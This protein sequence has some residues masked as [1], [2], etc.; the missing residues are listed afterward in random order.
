[1]VRFKNRYLVVEIVQSRRKSSV[2]KENLSDAVKQ[3][4]Q[5]NFGDF[6]S[7]LIN[8]TYQ[9]T[10]LMLTRRDRENEPHHFILP[11]SA[12]TVALTGKA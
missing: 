9:G 10:F 2:T 5:E 6:G 7:S 8:T 1:M 3:S 11:I 4:I 12:S